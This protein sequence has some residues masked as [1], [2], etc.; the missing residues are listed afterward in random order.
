M[1]RFIFTTACMRLAT[2]EYYSFP[3]NFILGAS[4]SSYQ[5]EGAWN[6]SDKAE[7][8]WDRFVHD[9]SGHIANNE[10]GDIACDSYHKYKEDVAILKELGFDSYRFSVSWGRILPEG[11]AHYVSQDGLNYYN[12]LL[13]ELLANNIK[14]LVT[15][16]HWDHPQL[17]EDLGGWRNDRMVEWFADYARIVFRELGPKIKYFVTINEPSILATSG[18][19]KGTKA[20][21]IQDSGRGEYLATH[22][23]LKAHATVYHIY[24]NE[25]KSTQNAVIGIVDVCQHSYT[26]DANDNTSSQVG[27]EFN[28]GWTFHPIFSKEGDY[29]K[30]FK[31]QIA[32]KSKLQGYPRS[33]LPNFSQEWITYIR[34]SAD[35]LGLNHYTAQVVQPGSN[36]QVPSYEDDQNLVVSFRPEWKATTVPIFK[37]VPKG[38]GD[39][40]REIAEA[41]NNPVIYVTENGVAL[42]EGLKDQTRIQ[43]FHDYV[44][45]LLLA[46]NRDGV[47]VKGYHIWSL[48]DNFEWDYGYG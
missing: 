42:N 24:Q 37:I 6:I 43:F 47:N 35:F 3:P 25:F 9:K 39:T 31:K 30:I 41:Y 45:E 28:C 12:K 18:Y 11:F 4:T 22:N 23:M 19:G 16:Y 1:F 44:R 26:K 33:R 27:F 29:P 13:D 46:I 5:I 21:G 32:E 36:A 14:P 48:L 15:I 38:F 34:G 2:S 20:P 8:I 17:I 7:S 40:L 10:T